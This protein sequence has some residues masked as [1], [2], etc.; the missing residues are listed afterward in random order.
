MSSGGVSCDTLFV[1]RCRGA[2]EVLRQQ[3]LRRRV[4]RHSGYK[5]RTFDLWL[6]ARFNSFASWVVAWFN[7]GCIV[8][9]REH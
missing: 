3:V 6:F 7:E 2:M 1:A 9:M 4:T 8:F 5:V